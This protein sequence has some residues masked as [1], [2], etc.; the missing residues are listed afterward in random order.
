MPMRHACHSLMVAAGL[1]AF[2]ASARSAPPITVPE[3]HTRTPT[4]SIP[5]NPNPAARV[6]DVELYVSTDGGR[7]WTFVT[8]AAPSTRREDN[9]FRYTAPNDG[10]YWFGVRSI[11]QA[12]VASPATLEQLQ[13]GLVVH[14]DRRPPIVQLRTAAGNRPNVVGVEWDVRDEH[15]DS[16]HFVMEYRVP[17]QSEWVAQSVDAKSTG[18]QFWEL[19]T[20]PKI[21]VRLRVADRAGNEAEATIALQ[22]G[23]S[24]SSASTNSNPNSDPFPNNSATSTPSGRPAIHYINSTQIAIPFRISSVGP[25]GVQVMD[26]WYTRDLGRTWQ[27]MPRA[28]DDNVTLPT[29]PGEGDALRKQFVFTAPSEGLYGF[30][31]VLRSGVGIGDADPRPGDGPKQLVEVDVTKP[32]LEMR[33]SRGAGIE[34]RNV[35]IEWSARDKNLAERPVTLLHS[36]TKDGP[37][38]PI[39]AD[40]DAK[41]R[42]V[43]TVPDSGP[44]QFYVQARAVDKAGNATT[45]ISNDRITV[46]LNRPKA[47]FDVPTPAK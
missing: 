30:T 5:F 2:T 35:T 12:N 22:P 14:L 28:N 34:V 18:T 3:H 40:Q 36:A 45:S 11:D 32:E 7:T 15:F 25:S 19:T 17:G 24:G 33:V 46:D 38:E 6:R 29:T 31:V 41:G 16:S 43:W 10:S 9:R 37:W 8:Q 23:S 42:Y 4:F 44:F 21:E 13:A 20:A 27:K 39:V 26:L 47:E 1:L